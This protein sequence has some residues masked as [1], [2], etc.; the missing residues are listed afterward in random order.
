MKDLLPFL[1]VGLSTGSIYGLAG[2]G[3][4]LTYRT[5]GVFNFAH[6]AVAALGA[7]AFYELRTTHG[8]PWPLALVVSVLAVGVLGGAAVAWLTR[9]LA[10]AR[11]E[12]ALV[13]TVGLLLLVQGFL[14]WKF[15]GETR[16]FPPFLPTKTVA[17]AS[18]SIQYGQIIVFVV[19]AALAAGL[20][21]FLRTTTIGA[22]MRGVVDD[23]SLVSLAG[24]GPDR[25]QRFSWMLGCGLASLSGILIAPSLGLDSSLLTLLVVQ[26]FGACAIGLFSSLPLTYAGGLVVGVAAALTTKFGTTRVLQ[27]LGPSVPFLILFIALLVVPARRLAVTPRS[28]KFKPKLALPRPALRALAGL[29]VVALALVPWVADVRLTS[30]TAA[31]TLVPAFLSLALLVYVAGSISLCHAA[32]AALGATTFAHLT[33]FGLPWLVALV[34]AGLA[35]VPLGAIVAIPAI[36]LQGIYLALATF[37]FGILL[38]KVAYP[39]A[40]MFGTIGAR[41]APRP[42]F[43]GIDGT[44]ERGFYLVVLMVALVTTL[45]VV[46]LIRNRIGRLLLAMG[47]SP[48]AL[49]THGLSVNVTR[50]LVF[51]ISAAMAGISGALIASQSGRVGGTG[52][53][54]FQSL[55]WLAVLVMCG[56]RPVLSAYL[57]AGMLLVV[58]AYA[59]DGFVNYQ[60]MLFGAAALLATLLPE[61]NLG[62]RLESSDDR[63]MRSPVRARSGRLTAVTAA[64]AGALAAVAV[65]AGVGA[66]V[67]EA[68]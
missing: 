44:D 66:G 16:I 29:G 33:T 21:V 64:P 25:V 24:Y 18:V 27:G 56:R 34:L 67:G 42:H 62:R 47:D 61:L 49:S 55:L 2:I 14:L 54:S 12:M 38:E 26:A 17:F 3:L 19:A 4:V 60:T 39:A 35:V 37:G 40:V 53:T 13:A 9:Y 57:A 63:R 15:G 36:R 1:V 6:G 50:V 23:R 58:P 65:R 32:F 52:F 31:L 30:Y 28:F 20:Y 59:P 22:V 41:R 51:C 46:A 45:L 11:T 5:A 48:T 10:G 43:W 8:W 7:Y 68:R